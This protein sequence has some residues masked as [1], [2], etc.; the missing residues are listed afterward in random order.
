MGRGSGAHF[1]WQVSTALP[2]Q[3]QKVF[4][5]EPLITDLRWAGGDADLDL[6]P[7]SQPLVRE[8]AAPLHGI[9]PEDVDALDLHEFRRGRLM[10]R[11]ATSGITVLAVAASV[12]GLLC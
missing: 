12:A 7:A 1:D 3:L 2:I 4:S 10:R 8:L 11:L 5:E 9:P 6:N